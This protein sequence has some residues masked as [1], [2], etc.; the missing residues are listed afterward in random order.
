MTQ[1]Q[2][3]AVILGAGFSRRF[4]SDKRLHE[5]GGSSVAEI[6]VNNYRAAFKNVRVVI[7]PEDDELANLLESFDVELLKS[8]NA[9]SGM[10]HSLSDGV[11]NLDWHWA[12]IALLDMPFIKRETLTSLQKP[13]KQ[14]DPQIYKIIRARLNSDPKRATHPVGFH[15]SLFHELKRCTGEVGAKTVIQKYSSETHIIESEDNG[16]CLDIDKPS[17]L[18]LANQTRKSPS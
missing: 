7:R 17:D 8:E 13:A 10:G 2:V 18:L 3:G 14:T 12:F 15:R 1:Q 16:L 5:L 4:G 11:T 9:E 6:T